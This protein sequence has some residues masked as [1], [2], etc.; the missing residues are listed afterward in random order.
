MTSQA[1]RPPRDGERVAVTCWCDTS[2]VMVDV[3]EIRK[4][5]TRSCGR[6]GCRPPQ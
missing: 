2:I 5:R 6:P 4:G 1:M 3:V